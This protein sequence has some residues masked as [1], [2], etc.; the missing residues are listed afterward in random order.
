MIYKLNAATTDVVVDGFY[1]QLWVF[2]SCVLESL[3]NMR[4]L[5]NVT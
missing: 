1:P 5:L 4:H 2:Q 3:L